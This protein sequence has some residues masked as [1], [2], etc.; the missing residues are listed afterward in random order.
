M[1]P[2]GIS[3]M[4]IRRRTGKLEPVQFEKVYKRLLQLGSS[5]RPLEEEVACDA[6]RFRQLE[7]NFSVVAQQAITGIYDGITTR[8]IDEVTAGVAVSMVTQHPDYGWLA[9]RILMNRLHKEVTK[10]VQ[11]TFRVMHAAGMLA[12]DVYEVVKKHYKT[13]DAMLNFDNDFTYD[14]FAVSTLF[15]IYLTKV[16]GKVAERPQHMLLRV[17]SGIV[18]GRFADGGADLPRAVVQV[19]HAR[20]PDTLQRRDAAQSAQVRV[21][22]NRWRIRS[23]AFIGR[24]RS[25]PW[26]ASTRVASACTFTTSAAGVRE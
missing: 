7:C 12:D 18:E 26:S 20:Q 19:L 11:G 6:T 10:G 17:A 22:C 25:Q 13:L 4:N 2:T 8:E 3:R 1:A 14:Y 23:R 5:S 24:L 21:F 9:S 16:D 15:T